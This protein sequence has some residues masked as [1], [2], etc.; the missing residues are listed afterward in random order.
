MVKSKNE[1]KK[2]WVPQQKLSLELSTDNKSS[3]VHLF[4]VVLNTHYVL[5]HDILGLDDTLSLKH[6]V[7]P[8]S[9]NKALRIVLHST[10]SV[11]SIVSFVLDL[12]LLQVYYNTCVEF[13]RAFQRYMVFSP[14]IVV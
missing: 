6:S 14:A 7:W 11:C 5:L 13:W 9:W 1:N 12:P 3:V 8:N 2:S 4:S 10:T